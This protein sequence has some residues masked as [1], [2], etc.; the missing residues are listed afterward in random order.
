[1]AENVQR[2]KMEMDISQ[3]ESGLNRLAALQQKVFAQQPPPVNLPNIVPPNFSQALT[4]LNPAEQLAAIARVQ[5]AMEA[6]IKRAQSLGAISSTQAQQLSASTARVGPNVPYSTDLAKNPKLAD[7]FIA[8][9]YTY[10]DV[11]AASKAKYGARA[12][13]YASKAGD[14]ATLEAAGQRAV[15]KG[16]EIEQATNVAKQQELSIEEQIV[17]FQ[18]KREAVLRRNIAVLEAELGLEASDTANIGI[19]NLSER[20][21][22]LRGVRHV[23]N[24]AAQ[25]GGKFSADASQARAAELAAIARNKSAL[26][27]LGVVAAE[28]KLIQET[29][30]AAEFEAL[31]TKEALATKAQR[32]IAEREYNRALNLAIAQELQLRGASKFEIQQARGGHYRGGPS[33]GLNSGEFF[34]SGFLNT[35]KYAAPSALIFGGIAGLSA[36]LKEAQELQ[37]IMVQ[38]RT[39]MEAF[40]RGEQFAATKE[41]ILEIA[42]SSGVSSVEVANLAFQFQGAFGGDTQKAIEETKSAIEATTVTGLELKETIDAFTAI[43]QSFKDSNVT[44]EEISDTALGLQERFGVLAKETIS[45]ASDLAPV[46]SEIGLTARELEVLGAV[47]Q[48]YSGK[49]GTTLAEAFGRILPQ[50]QENGVEIIGLFR[51]LG[52]AGDEAA[53]SLTEAFASAN[54]GDALKTLIG[55]YDQLTEAQQKQLISLLGG[56]REAAALIPVLENSGELFRELNREQSDAGK[57]SEYFGEVQGTLSRQ[58]A[59]LAENLKQVGIK[60]FEGGLGQALTSI[61]EAGSAIISVFGEVFSIV[62]SVNEAFG[63]IPITLLTII[64][65]FKILSA[66]SNVVVDSLGKLIVTKN[67][68]TAATNVNTAAESANA[69]GKSR[70][71]LAAQAESGAIAT[72]GAVGGV[73]GFGRSIGSAFSQGYSGYL[74]TRTPSIPVAAAQAGALGNTGAAAARGLGVFGATARGSASALGAF[75]NAIPSP[76][77]WAGLFLAV[78]QL[79]STVNEI[80][81]KADTEVKGVIDSIRGTPLDRRQSKI[82]ELRNQS[83]TYSF[84][85]NFAA[86]VSGYPTSAGLEDLA[87]QL[88]AESAAKGNAAGVRTAAERLRTADSKQLSSMGIK[89]STSAVASWTELADRIENGTATPEDFESA[90]EI[91]DNIEQNSNTFF[92]EYV[93]PAVEEGQRRATEA[94][95]QVAEDAAKKD[96]ALGKLDNVNSEI[97]TIK[98]KIDSGEISVAQGLSELNSVI[99]VYEDLVQSDPNALQNIEGAEDKYINAKKAQTDL[100]SEAAYRDIQNFQKFSEFTGGTDQQGRV[101][102]LAAALRN[103]DLNPA[104][105]TKITEELLSAY[106]ELYDYRLE[107]A[108]SLEEQLQLLDYGIKVD[109]NTRISVISQQLQSSNADM[110]KFIAGLGN[111]DTRQLLTSSFDVIA[112]LMVLQGFS[113]EEATAEVLRGR[114]ITNQAKADTERKKLAAERAA[115]TISEDEASRR[116]SWIAD[117]QKA[118]DDA[119]RAAEEV[120]GGGTELGDVYDPYAYNPQE[121]PNEA[122]KRIAEFNKARISYLKALNEGDSVTQAQLDIQAAQQ[123]LA[124]LPQGSKEWYEAAADLVSA[125]NALKNALKQRQQSRFEYLKAL[126]ADDP[127]ASAQVDLQAAQSQLANATAD[128]YDSAR[129]AVV[130][131]Q[132][133]LREAEEGRRKAYFDYLKQ[134]YSDDPLQAAN[135]SLQAAQYALAT[136]SS[137]EEYYGALAQMDAAQKEQREAILEVQKAQMELQAA[138]VAGDPV[139]SAQLAQKQAELAINNAKGEAERLRAQAQKVSADRQLEDAIRGILQAQLDLLLAVAE[140]GGDTVKAAQISLDAAQRRLIDAQNRFGRGEIGAADLISAQ[141]DVVRAQAQLRDARLQDQLEQYQFLYDMGRITRGQFIA[142]LEQLK[143]VPDLTAQQIRDLDR[144]IKQLKGELQQDLQF[145]LPTNIAL[146]T[147]YEVRRL[148]QSTQGGPGGPQVGYQDN[149]IVEINVQVNNGTDL[150]TVQ[151]IFTDALGTNRF[152]SEPRRY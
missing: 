74:A 94:S 97:S 55:S 105:R 83:K 31:S 136:A 138:Y 122:A 40:G 144:Q 66:I 118:A 142:Y 101:N 123:Q 117:I 134:I 73:G 65:A 23:Q 8:Q 32:I 110:Q 13:V 14:V 10:A 39:Q 18:A 21:Q 44:I 141:T 107:A 114:Q 131:A 59:I 37:K 152:G 80:R 139:A 26:T 53:A 133:A 68:D 112:Q 2:F 106:Q 115:G 11:E 96:E 20:E 135:I 127:V 69:A 63:G 27:A 99:S 54:T 16:L 140:A 81:S 46:A 30:K 78:T 147:L 19:Q 102:N 50:I 113:L 89:Y 119:G 100:V 98:N 95:R 64:G 49:S 34:S 148:N 84:F 12:S 146:P 91:V 42:S 93:G 87:K 36:S 33:S 4:G 56:R 149:R 116:E 29:V 22:Q 7:P 38:I 150:A 60:L 111:E 71:A 109:D 128:E 126:A 151:Q 17:A 35:I 85:D 9:G 143:Q 125:Q 103:P 24:S 72:G 82:D 70:L 137:P 88:E 48:K 43:T 5:G 77:V 76:V 52:P 41:S 86:A 79:V 3:I 51:S 92:N 120:A 57:T 145:N 25:T 67:A 90:Q 129:A 6:T 1:M 61:V 121:D 15:A 58:V 62:A 124:L 108:T 130:N 132:R 47:A 104:D 45:F 75:A 28:E